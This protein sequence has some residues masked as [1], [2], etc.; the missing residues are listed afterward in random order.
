MIIIA[1]V[2]VIITVIVVVFTYFWRQKKYDDF[3][4]Q[5]SVCLKKLSEINNRYEFLDID[6]FDQQHT[7][8]NETHYNNISC[9]DYLIYQLQYMRQAVSSQ[10]KK[11]Q[12]N[13]Q[14]YS[15]YMNEVKSVKMFGQF[16]SPIGKL[17]L[18]KLL[19]TEKSMLRSRVYRQPA[20]RFYIA[21]TLYCSDIKG[22]VYNKKEKIFF[23]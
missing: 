14:R 22:R 16:Q 9:N 21:V 2:S 4:L 20:V 10:I 5:N 8:D 11:I 1:A 19:K 23:R 15:N 3:I 13:S 12:T 7:Y 6:N 18:E 17:K